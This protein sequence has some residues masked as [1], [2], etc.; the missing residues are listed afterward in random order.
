M[1]KR[2]PDQKY[3][4]YI[5]AMKILIVE[6]FFSGSHQQWAEGLQR[7]SR[8]QISI[9]S[10]RGRHWKWRMFG[11]A[12]TLARQFCESSHQPDLILASDMLDLSTFIALSR[13]KM[14]HLKYAIYF[15]EN[16][17]TYPWS[18]KDPDLLKRPDEAATGTRNNQYGFIN[19]TSAFAA[20]A[21]FFNSEFHRQ[22]FLTTLP[23][24]L[25]QFPDH[26]E[27]AAV[28]AIE[29]KSEV[30]PL[31]M[32]LQHFDAFRSSSAEVVGEG[33]PILL[34]N[35]RWEYDKNPEGFFQAL[36]RLQ[37]E[38]VPFRLVVLGDRY[39]KVPAIFAEAQ[40]R[41]ATEIL[42]WGYAE[43]FADYAHWLWRADLLPV[44]S[45]QDF[46][47][48]SVVEAIYCRCLPIL[49]NRLAYPDHLPVALHPV[50]L[51]NSD[52]EFYQMLKAQL[53]KPVAT[54][55]L[56]LLQQAV[57]PYDWRTL[58][59]QYDERLQR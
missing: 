22:S 28:A 13:N 44:T 56:D 36:F 26:R 49:P 43:S 11:G 27:L 31:G 39:R 20:D 53:L 2:N 40:R 18:P 14:S 38:A 16:Q 54:T 41:L 29:A 57:Q 37:E 21:V 55:T 10:L 47:G 42:H 45:N 48:G 6:P 8:H 59:G 34:W 33:A 3:I 25:K 19:F 9:M 1:T 35:H 58:I 30:L 50:C 23:R 17:I 24:F 46:F 7:F 5:A 52:E 32:D 4:P 51:Y 15:H 12:V